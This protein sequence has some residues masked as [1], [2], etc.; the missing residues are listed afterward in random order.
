MEIESY[1]EGIPCNESMVVEDMENTYS[2]GSEL[3]PKKRSKKKRE[4]PMDSMMV[5]WKLGR[6]PIPPD[7]AA[8]TESIRKQQ[9]LENS[10][11]EESSTHVYS[12][13]DGYIHNIHHPSMSK[14]FLT[15]Y[16]LA[17]FLKSTTRKCK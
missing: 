7:I 6:Q 14:Y 8:Y 5:S 2:L 9:L 10:S 17:K 12:V 3:Q 15:S 13:N 16:V 1:R 4:S 11:E